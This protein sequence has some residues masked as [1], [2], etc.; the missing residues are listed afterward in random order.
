MQ[1]QPSSEA[2]WRLTLLLEKSE[3][4]L[5]YYIRSDSFSNDTR[6]AYFCATLG[7]TAGHDG[8]RSAAPHK[9][10]GAFT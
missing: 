2:E 9:R 3:E 7:R 8:Q 10:Y 5:L 1:R 4:M 6:R